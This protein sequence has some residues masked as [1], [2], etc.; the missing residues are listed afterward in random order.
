MNSAHRPRK[1]FGQNFLQDQHVIDRIVQ[2]INPQ[3]DDTIVEIGP[4]QAALTQPL[5]QACEDLHVVEIDRDLLVQLRQQLPDHVTIHEA[6]ALAFDFLTCQSQSPLRV[7]GNLPY[8]ISTPLLFHLLSFSAHIKDMHFMLQKEVVDRICAQPNSKAYGR[9]SV[10]MQYACQTTALFDVPATAFH[11]AP[12]VESSII[13][14]QP[15][16]APA[17]PVHNLDCFAELVKTAFSQRRK[18]LRNNLKNLLDA[19]EIISIGIDTGLRPEQLTVADYV[20]L[21]NHWYQLT[22]E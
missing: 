13:R 5:A 12:K 10:M 14:L 18:T 4:G 16:A 19:N 6:D 9:L 8:N 15:Y 1:R 17:N 20:K 7:V 2:V 22:K 11:P 21:S 3:R